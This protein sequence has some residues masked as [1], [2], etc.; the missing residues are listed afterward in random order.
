MQNSSKFQPVTILKKSF[1]LYIKNI[2]RFAE[3]ISWVVVPASMLLVL[4][5]FWGLKENQV[6]FLLFYFYALICPICFILLKIVVIKYIKSAD[7]KKSVTTLSLY[8]EAFSGYGSFLLVLLIYFLETSLWSIFFIL[9][10]IFFK[11]IKPWTFVFLI[12]GIIFSY[13]YSLF[14]FTFCIDGKKG[15]QALLYSRELL[16][17]NRGKFIPYLLFLTIVMFPFFNRLLHWADNVYGLSL[18]QSMFSIFFNVALVN[19]V[20][21]LVLIFGN[22]FVYFVYQDFKTNGRVANAV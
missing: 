20:F 10:A 18:L 5:F 3:I 16:R 2:L 9:S 14:F 12:P 1:F 13:L 7:E 17:N 15:R 6:L 22:V 4:L 19:L 21:G 11:E 8:A